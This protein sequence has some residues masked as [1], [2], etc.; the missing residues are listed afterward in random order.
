[1]VILLIVMFGD[2]SNSSNL[3]IETYKEDPE[4]STQKMFSANDKYDSKYL[5]KIYITWNY[6][7]VIK[8]LYNA[9]LL[10]F[11]SFN[12]HSQDLLFR[13]F[14][15]RINPEYMKVVP[16]HWL[17][18][19]LPTSEVQVFMSIYLLFLCI[20]GNLSQILVMVAYLR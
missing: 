5:Q 20:P 8:Y 17:N 1:M 12:N 9:E 15:T 18:L 13:A 14:L 6:T 2:V 11:N 7:L 10:F 16:D 3:M 19:E 4:G